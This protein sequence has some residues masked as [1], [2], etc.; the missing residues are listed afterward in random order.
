M[1]S[2]LC[3][4]IWRDQGNSSSSAAL[5][6]V[7]NIQKFI[8]NIKYPIIYFNQCSSSKAASRVSAVPFTIINGDTYAL[9]N[10]DFDT[11]LRKIDFAEVAALLLTFFTKCFWF[12]KVY[13]L[14]LI[15]SPGFLR[16]LL[17]FFTRI[18]LVWSYQP[19]VE[20]FHRYRFSSLFYPRI[21]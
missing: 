15:P 17:H 18:L 5:H 11:N 21:S 7:S 13:N 9:C 2:G 14:I 12:Q 20:I 16:P 3:N 6:Q 4:E 10:L 8:S 1:G 19:Y